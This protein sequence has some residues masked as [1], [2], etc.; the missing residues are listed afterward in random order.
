MRVSAVS[1]SSLLVVRRVRLRK[2][3][4]NK[5]NLSF[6]HNRLR[7]I[8]ILAMAAFVLVFSGRARAQDSAQ[9][10]ELSAEEIIQILQENP[11]VLAEAKQEIVAQLRDRGYN[12]SVGDITD[13][14]LFNQIRSDDRGRQ[15]AGNFLT[16]RKSTCLN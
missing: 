2:V 10:T 15:I 6:V 3:K 14:R 13:D 7:L 4:G 11:D 9:D 1:S 8:F 16:D 5:L 12:V